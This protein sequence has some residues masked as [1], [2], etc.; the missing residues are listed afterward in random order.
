MFK[1]SFKSLGAK[2]ILVVG[3]AIA[4]VLTVSNAFVIWKTSH[5]IIDLTMEDTIAE[6]RAIANS[7]RTDIGLVSGSVRSMAHVLA[8]AYE[9]KTM[10]FEGVSSALEANL[11]QS[12]FVFGSWFCEKQSG[13][14]DLSKGGMTPESSQYRNKAGVLTPYWR[15]GPDGKM[16]VSTFDSEFSKD[17][18][19][20]A[21]KSKAGAITPAYLSA[22]TDQPVIMTSLTY[23]VMSGDEVIGVTGIDISLR[24]LTE[25]LS[26]LSPFENGRVTL[27]SQNGSWLVA[28]QP[29]LLMK[30]YTDSGADML[31]ETISTKETHY[32]ENLGLDTEHPYNRLMYPFEVPEMNA[33]WVL[34]I[35]VP[36]EALNAPMKEQTIM[37]LVAMA[38]VLLCVLGVLA[39]SVGRLVR[40]PLA[41]LL[42]DVDTLRAG[43]YDEAVSGQ[44]RS[45]ETGRV[46]MALEGFRSTL[47]GV[48]KMEE[49]AAEQRKVIESERLKSEQERAEASSV[50][51]QVVQVLGE[52]LTA[53]ANGNLMVRINHDFPGD[54]AKLKDDFNAALTSLED[55]V[56]T[57][58]V[59]VSGIGS[60]TSEITKAAMDLS[61]RTEQQAASLEETAAALNELTEQ[62]NSSAD[63]AAQAA[64]TVN[65]ACDEAEASGKTVNQAVGAMEGIAQ[66]S[67]EISRII[68]VIDEIA[69]Q[70]NLLA[71]NAGVEAARA[72]DAG[73]GFAVVAQEVRELAQ[74]SAT[75]AKEIKALINTSSNQ[76]SEGVEL[77]GKA[78]TT[79]QKI[80]EQVMQINHLIRQIS[81]SASEQ[82]SGLKQ[83][84]VA[85]SQMDQVTQQ[86]AAMVEETTAASV[87]LNGD[88]DSLKV[89]VSRFKIANRN[90]NVD[91]KHAPNDAGRTQRPAPMPTPA[92]RRTDRDGTFGAAQ[93]FPS[94]TRERVQPIPMVSGNTA[95]AVQED[96]WTEF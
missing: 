5:R 60:G 93:T 74:R 54:Y 39:F 41:G 42:R 91:S 59:T 14:Y 62:V 51:Q 82:A 21:A 36:I 71:L 45:D 38:C 4:I 37:M 8:Q 11:E 77:V 73:K 20:L 67:Q 10:D 13:F 2:L 69:F 83:V 24:K 29:E 94:Q 78:G 35:D 15:R 9:G 50:Q 34:M 95:V 16:S 85:V 27:V 23:A 57:V 92:P 68:S 72:G 43:K 32:V 31:G 30:P 79:M 53:L 96:D 48:R 61:H 40:V 22:E 55:A 88:A 65:L 70:T 90:G 6:S 75:A 25:R 84:N 87:T 80:A 26:T 44:D 58:N 81:S 28:P 89:L 1:L 3:C 76:V 12:D 49:D 18:Y 47:A 56:S 66:S 86:N 7:L 33:T 64:K 52:G 63:N 19:A 46:A 17:W